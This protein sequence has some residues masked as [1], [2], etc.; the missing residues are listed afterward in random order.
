MTD[1]IIK[2]E[3]IDDLEPI[4]VGYLNDFEGVVKRALIQTMQM[5]DCKPTYDG[6]PCQPE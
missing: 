2:I 1:F 6:E 5:V 4:F 3:G